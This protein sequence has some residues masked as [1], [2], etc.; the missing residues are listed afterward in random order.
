MPFVVSG[1]YCVRPDV[2]DGALWAEAAMGKRTSENRV[3]ERL[4][5]QTAENDRLVMNTPGSCIQKDIAG[6]AG[7]ESYERARKTSCNALSDAT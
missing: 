7:R 1:K 2:S 6:K 3:A 4:A 5:E